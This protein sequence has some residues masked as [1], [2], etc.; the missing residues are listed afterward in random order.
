MSFNEELKKL[1]EERKNI[2]GGLNSIKDRENYELQLAQQQIKEKYEN[3]KSNIDR[4]FHEVT[5]ALGFL[6]QNIAKFS[7]FEKNF[8]VDGLIDIIKVYEGENF[9]YRE[10]VYSLDTKRPIK[11]ERAKLLISADKCTRLNN[12]NTQYNLITINVL[13]KQGNV[14][15]L[16][17]KD[18]MENNIKFYDINDSEDIKSNSKFGRLQYLKQF[19]DFLISYKLENGLKEEITP[20][21]MEN[22]KYKFLYEHLE[23][24]ERYHDIIRF[25]EQVSEKQKIDE[26]AIHRDKILQRKLKKYNPENK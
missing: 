21:E 25:E 5:G 4:D 16:S 14:V 9:V 18:N 12:T 24:I 3:L 6:K 22:L 15:V 10:I 1:V 26:R 2:V 13:L 11:T 20:Q 23:E 19:I 17:Y 8:I 7:I